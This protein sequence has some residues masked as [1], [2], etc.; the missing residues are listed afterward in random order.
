VRELELDP[1]PAEKLDWLHATLPEVAG[2]IEE[3]LDWIEADPIDP[4]AKRRR[5][6]AGLWAI[7]RP[8]AGSEW[9][10]LWDEEQA[11]RPVV[12]FIGETTSL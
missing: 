12:R 11:G 3:C 8:G 6:T 10:L 4:R 1:I 2:K 7:L 9:L 5:F